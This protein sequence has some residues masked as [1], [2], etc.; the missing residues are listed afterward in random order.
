[1]PGR[2]PAN[3]PILNRSDIA[4]EARGARWTTQGGVALVVVFC[5]LIVVSAA[6]RSN[7]TETSGDHAHAGFQVLREQPFLPPDFD[8]QVFDNLWQV[9]P[10][11]LKRRAEKAS[12]SER[13]RMAF[14]RYGLMEADDSQKKGPALGYVDDGNGGWVMNCLAC[15]A[16]KVAGRVIPGLPNSHF[17]LQ[18]LTDDVRLTK[19]K[20]VKPLSH[21]DLGSFQFPLGTTNGTTNSVMFGV[22]LGTYRDK[23]M[24][25]DTGQSLPDLEHHDMDAPPFW[26]VKYKS[27]LYCDG[28]APKNHRVIMQFML[29]PQNGPRTLIDWEEDF[30][31]V[32]AWIESVEPPEYPW[33]IDK[34]LANNGEL[35]FA[36]NCARCHGRY[37]ETT[38][39]PERCI[40]I[41]T[42]GTDDVRLRALTIEHRRWLKEGW[43]SFYGKDSVKLDP[44]GYVAPPLRGIWAS[45]P[46]LHNGSV[47]TLWHLLHPD[48]RPTVWKRSENGFDKLRIGLEVDEYTKV[49]EKV[50]DSADRRQYFDTT[51]R[52]KSAVGH[53]FPDELT[54]DEKRAVLEY[55]KTL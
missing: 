36:K 9:W 12:P 18:T 10:E 52:G 25:V 40:P 27:Q 23:D 13:R 30:R 35:V 8:Q 7:R 54:P 50:F 5:S 6:D 55:L 22:I 47:P 41:E 17:A 34:E 45:A 31:K 1:M 48:E 14:A 28:F 42:I 49:P 20:Q 44:Q 38:E 4:I 21:L 2:R 15:H 24:N 32:L 3:S 16:G 39:Y 11:P 19:L 43:L 37:G 53:R 29:L 46:Y 33:E 26:N 51:K